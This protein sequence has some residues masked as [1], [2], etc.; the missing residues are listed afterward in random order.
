MAKRVRVVTARDQDQPQRRIVAREEN[1]KVSKLTDNEIRARRFATTTSMG[2]FHR[3]A[4]DVSDSGSAQFYSPQLSTDFLEKPQNLRERRAFYRFFYNT[5]EIVGSAV[6]IHSTLPMSKLRLVPPKG[7][8]K[9][10]NDYVFKFFNEMCDEMK[11]F[12]TLIEISHEFTL[13][14][15][16][17]HRDA[18]VRTPVGYKRAEDVQVGDMLLTNQGR[19]RKVTHRFVRP[20]EFIQRIS[21]WKDFRDLPI[22]GEHPVEVLR[23]GEFIFV[24]AEE[25]SLADYIRVTWPTD[26]EDQGQVTLSYPDYYKKTV[27]GYERSIN[28]TRS[29][30]ASGLENRKKIVQWLSTLTEPVIKTYKDLS[31]ELGIPVRNL[32][33]IVFNIT[34]E[35]DVRFHERLGPAG[36]QKGSQIKWYPLDKDVICVSEDY[37]ILTTKQIKGIDAFEVSEDFAYLVGYWLGDGTLARDSSRDTWGRGLWQISAELG[38]VENIARVRKILVAIFGEESIVEWDN[39]EQHYLKIKGNPAFIEWW[40]E[41]FGETSLGKNNKRIPEWFIKLPTEKLLHFLGGVVDSDGGISDGSGSQKHHVAAISMVSRSI[42]D[43]IR[44]IVLKCGIICGY[45]EAKERGTVL[46]NGSSCLS[47]K[48]YMVSVSDEVSCRELMKYSNKKIP[49]EAHFSDMGRYWVRTEDGLAFKVRSIDTEDYGDLVYNFEVEEDHT[50]Q[51]AGFSTHNCFVF[52]EDADWKDDL[53]P[54]EAERKKQEAAQRSQFLKEKY[55]IVDKNPLFKGWRKLLIL[56]PDQVRVRKLPLSDDVAIEYMPDPETRKFLTSDIPIDPTDPSRKIKSTVSKELQ[57]A[58]RQSGVIPLDTDPN[59]GSHVYHLARKKSQYEPMGVSIIER[60]I[61]TLVLMDKL[62]KAQTSIAS[63]HMTPMRIVWAEG[64]NPDD[65]DNLREQVD[66]AL[67]DPDFSIIANYEVHW[68]EMGSQGRLLDIESENE[69]AMNRLFAG[70]GVTREI[71]TGEGSYSGSRISLEIM[72][73]QYLLFRE[74]IQDYVENN[75]F[76]PVARKKGFVE[77]DEYGNETLLYPHLSFT[78]L[79]IRDNEQ[80]FDAAFQLYQK[81]SISVDLILDILN[82]DPDSTKEKIEHD[83]FTVNDSIFNE[84]MRNIYT[85]VAAPLVEKT[86]LVQKLAEYLK[87]K[88]NEEEKPPEGTSRFSTAKQASEVA[89]AMTE[90]QRIKLAKAVKYFQGNPQALDKLFRSPK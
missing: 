4:G 64:L 39:N 33:S 29:R 47:N 76:K 63:R 7:K 36:W 1:P 52:S 49:V 25:L 23:D 18:E 37:T 27:D 50:F 59:S 82:I 6:D 2:G 40:A 71:L 89:P 12:K 45:R 44:D 74:I 87:L 20:A 13:F 65:V 83:L 35:I 70:L 17:L 21:C 56:P 15:N 86:D 10:Q 85:N 72:N 75:L 16:C 79:A 55:G 30:M 60:Y 14:G 81:G 78:R 62:R 77:Y 48:M 34:N 80:F 84:V 28:I 53:P 31:A 58:I 32:Q 9:H 57:E 69:S 88:M 3:T 42:M 11:L 8:N 22:T 61:N 38:C 26:V 90:D 19:Y 66:L 67:V 5:N 68:E 43:P 41:N 46:P 51:V 73:N 24:K 54:D